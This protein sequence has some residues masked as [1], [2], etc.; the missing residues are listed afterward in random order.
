MTFRIKYGQWEV[1][2][3]QDAEVL[4]GRSRAAQVRLND[5]SV[6]GQHARFR[7]ER[8][9]VEVRDL[10]SRNGVFV[11]GV[12]TRGWTRV[13]DGAEVVIGTQSMRVVEHEDVGDPSEDGLG[14]QTTPTHIVDPKGRRVTAETYGPV[15]TLSARERQ[16][17]SLI[18]RGFTQR[19]AGESLD[20]SIKT[21]E[22][23]VR[24]IR[25]KTGARSRA[26]IAD[27][28]RVAGIVLGDAQTRTTGPEK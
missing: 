3:A 26:D 27:Y 8:G 20:V 17:A 11:D 28:A 21:I 23:Y 9:R 19:E 25:E 10:D 22:T 2:L 18:A 4:V 1:P 15:A 6:S 24:R 5:P 16:V 13:P 7:V 12:R 14:D